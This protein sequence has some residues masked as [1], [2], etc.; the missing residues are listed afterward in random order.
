[1]IGHCKTRAVATS[2][3]SAGSRWKGCGSWVDS[4]TIRGWRCRSDTPCPARAR[5]IQSPTGRSSLS[6]PYS[7]SFATSQQEMILTPKTGSAPSSRSSRCLGCSRSGRETHQTQMWVSSRITAGRPSPR[8]QQAPTAHGTREPNLEGFG[9]RPSSIPR[10]SRP[11]TLQPAGRA[12]MEG[13]PKRVRH[14]HRLSSLSSVLARPQYRGFG[15]EMDNGPI[16]TQTAREHYS[17]EVPSRQLDERPAVEG[18]QRNAESRARL[19]C[20]CLGVGDVFFVGALEVFD[21]AMV[22]VPDTGGDF[23]DQIVIVG[24]QKD[25]ALVFLEGEVE[26]VDGLEIEVIGGFVEH[27]EVGLLEHEAAEDE[28][29]GFAAGERLGG[30]E[31]IV[32]GEQHFAEEPAQF[33]LRG[34][35]IE[36][37]QPLDGGQPVRDRDRKSTTSELQSPMYLV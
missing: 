27:Q 24:D 17:R 25:G 15:H 12:Q 32:A 10:S 29:G 3:W 13:R 18:S 26:G 22:E 30:L 9:R 21:V 20:Y 5:S 28:A 34:L 16:R 35:R 36:L 33:L 14:A 19:R 2:S 8:R 23:V 1:M 7:T 31:R 11:P 4:T 6:L 37:V